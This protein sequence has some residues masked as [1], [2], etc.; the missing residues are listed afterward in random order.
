MDFLNVEEPDAVLATDR[1]RIRPQHGNKKRKALVTMGYKA[2]YF[3]QN[4]L[5]ASWVE[6]GG[7]RLHTHIYLYVL[8][9]DWSLAK[10]VSDWCRLVRICLWLV[11]CLMPKPNCSFG[12]ISPLFMLQLTKGQLEVRKA[13]YKNRNPVSPCLVT[14]V[15]V[16][17]FLALKWSDTIVDEIVGN[18][19]ASLWSLNP[20]KY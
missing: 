19:L 6:S 2:L 18:L 15:C 3:V 10:L 17:D 1:F 9:S 11:F 14:W 8:T 7:L 16:A 12:G 13:S 4:Y 5:Q 20:N